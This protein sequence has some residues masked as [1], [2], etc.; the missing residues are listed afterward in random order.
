MNKAS[1]I[2]GTSFSFLS[3]CVHWNPQGGGIGRE[4]FEEMTEMFP[5]QEMQWT[6]HE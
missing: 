1:V 6:S 5:T 2:C 4:L 3:I